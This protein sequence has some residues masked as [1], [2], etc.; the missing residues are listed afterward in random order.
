MSEIFTKVM[1]TSGHTKILGGTQLL[2]IGKFIEI[3]KRICSVCYI[4]DF[5]SMSTKASIK[6]AEYNRKKGIQCVLKYYIKEQTERA[7]F[8]R[9]I[10][11]SPHKRI[12]KLSKSRYVCKFMNI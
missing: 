6:Q 5:G 7:E 11:D 1:L 9:Y 8:I 4:L 3:S 2:N 10:H 12:K